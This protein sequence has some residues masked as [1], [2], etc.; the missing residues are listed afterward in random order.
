VKKL[1]IISLLLAPA[2]VFAQQNAT[3]KEQALSSK[4]LEEINQN[5]E[6]R[7][8]LIESQMQINDLRKQLSDA[9]D[10]AKEEKK[11]DQ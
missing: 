6:Y 4:L 1:L 2:S 9:Q 11:Q 7:R 3:P 8:A 10:K 5:I